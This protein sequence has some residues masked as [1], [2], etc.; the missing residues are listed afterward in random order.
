MQWMLLTREPLAISDT[1]AKPSS[2]LPI[3]TSFAGKSRLYDS[4]VMWNESDPVVDG[5][6]VP[7]DHAVVASAEGEESGLRDPFDRQVVG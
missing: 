4:S 2:P 6:D 1:T 5:R 7:R 3:E